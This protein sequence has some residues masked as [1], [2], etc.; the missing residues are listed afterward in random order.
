LK[1]LNSNPKLV[2]VGGQVSLIDAHDNL[3]GKATYPTKSKN[4][5]KYLEFSNCFAHPAV[6]FRKSNVLKVGGYRNDFPLA[7]DYELW[8]R[9]SK[10]WLL[11]NIP[12]TVIKYRI[13]NSQVSTEKFIVQLCSTIEI[14]A[15]EFNLLTPILSQAL[16]KVQGNSNSEVVKSILKIP[17]IK[18]NR[19]FFSSIALMILIRGSIY[20]G[21]S[22]LENIRLFTLALFNSFAQTSFQLNLIMQK[23]YLILKANFNS[24]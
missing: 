1:E 8:V 13:H 11:G 14:I 23:K 6:M 21:N 19:K 5:A 16:V 7:E 17:D 12:N 9:L 20:T 22:R 18:R 3:V 24:N 15:K 10:L 2:L 4:I